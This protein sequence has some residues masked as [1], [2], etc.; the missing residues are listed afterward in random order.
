VVLD[1]WDMYPKDPRSLVIPLCSGK[2]GKCIALKL[3]S[4][5]RLPN[6]ALSKHDQAKL[7]C[8]GSVDEGTAQLG[9]ISL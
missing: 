2:V 7:G 1:L 6:M 5:A 9:G 3:L 8:I 4:F